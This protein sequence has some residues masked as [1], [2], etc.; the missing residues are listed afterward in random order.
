[1]FRLCAGL[2]RAVLLLVLLFR[3]LLGAAVVPIRDGG[4]NPASLGKGDWIWYVSQATNKLGGVAPSVVNLPTLMS[5]YKSQGLQY[6]IVKAGT[7]S[8]NFNGSGSSPQFNSNLVYHAHAAGLLIFAYT[9]SYDDDVP[10][11]I[12][13]AASCF[14]LGADGWV[15]DAEA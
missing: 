9:R 5:Y 13:M 6:I 1:M 15:I 11:E 8:T 2:G 10:G 4:I 14:A 12:A 7:G 3:W